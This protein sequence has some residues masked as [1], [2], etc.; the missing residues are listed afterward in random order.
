MANKIN[1]TQTRIEKLPIPSQGRIDYY[2]I[3]CPKLTCRVSATGNKSFVVLKKNS[4]GKAQRITLGRFPDISVFH[5]QE[6]TRSV[7]EDLSEGKNP[8]EEKQKR[9]RQSMTLAELLDRYLAHKNLKTSTANNYRL[10]FNQGF[11]DWADKPINSISR[12]IVLARHKS[13][14]GSATTRDNKLRVLRFL[15]RYAVAIHAI[16]EAPTDVLK[17]AGLWGKPKRKDRIIPADKLADW[18]HTVTGLD[19]IRAKVYLLLLLYTG[20][21]SGEAL[22]LKWKEIDFDRD[23]LTVRDTK[24]HND[25]STH[26]A[27]PLKPF[28]RELQRETGN[29]VYTLAGTGKNSIMETPRR[30]IDLVIE[31]TGVQFSPHDLRRTFATIGEAA[32]LPESIIKRLLNH[33]T[34]N[35]VKTGYIRTE[36]NTKRQAIERIADFIQEHITPADHNIVTLKTSTNEAKNDRELQR[37]HHP[38]AG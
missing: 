22:N 16:D 2:D 11:S 5:A 17:H 3:G 37:D 19:S 12:D 1:F 24:S 30:Q 8:I 23:S 33:S 14:T 13:L 18:Y 4:A 36:H 29:H 10:K 6:L 9:K 27:R 25:F 28:L 35:N 38:G 32:L 15:M 7:L 20:L 31:K 34:D 21:R 26:I